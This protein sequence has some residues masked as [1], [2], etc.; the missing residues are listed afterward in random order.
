[1]IY[2]Y[3]CRQEPPGN[4]FILP[5]RL[6]VLHTMHPCCPS[7]AV[8][9]L[10]NM[11]LC[12]CGVNC[13]AVP[14]QLDATCFRYGLPW[15]E[16]G[17]GLHLCD[18]CISGCALPCA[19]WFH[20]IIQVAVVYCPLSAPFVHHL[21]GRLPC[22]T[23]QHQPMLPLAKQPSSSTPAPVPLAAHHLALTQSANAPA[24]VTCAPCPVTFPLQ[25]TATAS[26]K[27]TSTGGDAS[28]NAD[29]KSTGGAATANAVAT[30]ETKKIID[31]VDAKA[32]AAAEVSDTTGGGLNSVMCKCVH[33]RCQCNAKMWGAC[34]AA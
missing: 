1:M 19:A 6:L 15:H 33:C 7:H 21:S 29:A 22:T 18:V 34:S 2:I 13:P 26:A 23:H 27:A 9:S 28:A 17:C 14:L 25:A 12:V 8:D 24:P 31:E 11:L 5:G 20:H 4:R 10:L 30:S 3:F 16:L 32:K